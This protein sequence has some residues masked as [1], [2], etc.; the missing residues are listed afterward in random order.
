MANFAREGRVN[1]LILLHGPNGSAK[2]TFIGCLMRAME[3][4]SRQPEGALYRF[5]WVFPTESVAKK[6]IGFGG[7]G[8]GA[9][10]ASAKV[11]AS[12]SIVCRYWRALLER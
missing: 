10:A 1:K 5:N 7:E 11:V 3:H 12:S 4:Y 6:G 9:A 2:S 8:G